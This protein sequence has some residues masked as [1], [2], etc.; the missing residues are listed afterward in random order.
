V[1]VTKLLLDTDI[2]LF[3]LRGNTTVLGKWA[4]LAASQ[5]VI[6]AISGY[7]IQKG[8]EANPTTR[9]SQR[10]TVLISQLEMEPITG[11]VA[12]E[13]AK[14]H[15]ALKKKGLS[16]GPADELIAAQAII[17]GATLVSN[18]TKHFEHVPRLKLE[19]WL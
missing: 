6:S 8:I 4:K 5:W 17:L 16:I 9:S 7:E 10:A 2:L 11:D 12:L 14:I 19:N 3:S 18:N 13:A 15:K 1:P